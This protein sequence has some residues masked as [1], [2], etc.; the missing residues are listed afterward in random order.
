MKLGSGKI[1]FLVYHR[2]LA[3]PGVNRHLFTSPQENSENNL[4]LSEHDQVKQFWDHHA[5]YVMLLMII[6]AAN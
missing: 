3:L 6:H 1:I 5:N 2:H 4:K